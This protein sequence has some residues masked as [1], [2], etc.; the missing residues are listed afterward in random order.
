MLKELSIFTASNDIE[1]TLGL[2]WRTATGVERT[3]DNSAPLVE[4]ADWYGSMSGRSALEKLAERMNLAVELPSMDEIRQLFKDEL[5]ASKAL[6][7]HRGRNVYS[8]SKA[9]LWK[10]LWMPF[11]DSLTPDDNTLEL[12]E[13]LV[14]LKTDEGGN[15]IDPCVE[16]LVDR[17]NRLDFSVDVIREKGHAPLIRAHR[18]PRSCPGR[19]AM[20]SHYDVEEPAIDAWQTDPW[21]LTEKKGR[22]Y[23]VGVGD[24]K[25]PLAQRLVLLE[26]LENTPELLWIIQGEEEIASPLAHRVIGQLVEGFQADFWLEENGYFDSNGT[27]RFLAYT[28]GPDEKNLPP[29]DKL[30]SLLEE[31]EAK[32]KLFGCQSRI[33]YRSLNKSFF[34][35][36]CPFGR[37]MPGGA[38]YLAIGLNDPESN[39]HR[40]NESVP[41]WTFPLHAL[42]FELT[43]CTSGEKHQ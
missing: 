25:G 20:Y 3:V 23:G 8:G 21:S 38:R 6:R 19:V 30:G 32:A 24:N 33:E 36:G 22:L 4:L 31:L 42:Q 16:L 10:S 43:L 14:S 40:S 27:Q 26:Q 9:A 17:L 35:E 34:P 2:L 12:L 13:K 5:V 39:V 15:G 37:A 11:R 41:M 29:D 18:P 1:L 7:L 28:V